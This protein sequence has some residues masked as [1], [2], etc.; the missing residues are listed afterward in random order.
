MAGSA[1]KVAIAMAG[2]PMAGGQASSLVQER[3]D[4]ENKKEA[5]ALENAEIYDEY[6]DLENKREALSLE[7]ARLAN[8]NMVLQNERLAQQNAA[9]RM[10]SQGVMMPSPMNHTHQWWAGMS[11]W[12]MPPAAC[13][14]LGYG[15]DLHM[16]TQSSMQSGR[17]QHKKTQ[18]GV[19]AKHAPSGGG[20][21]SC[22][23]ASFSS[24][25]TSYGPGSLTSISSLA[26]SEA[27]CFA[28]GPVPDHLR[29]TI[30]M[31]NI[32]NNYTREMLIELVS[33]EGFAGLYDLVYLPID[34][35]SKV[36]N[37]GYS[38]I[39]FV[40]PEV[41]TRFHS[42][43]NGFCQ[44]TLQSDKVCEVTWSDAIQGLDAHIERYKNS[45]V[46]HELVPDECK[47]AL[48]KGCERIPFPRPTMNIRAPR[49][50]QRKHQD[51]FAY[52]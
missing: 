35:Q 26:E 14:S 24:S 37:L 7:N 47:P 30:M 28:F 45:P 31:R 9:L 49:Q 16:T 13:N 18:N 40:D 34:F 42:H 21:G 4:L 20:E 8:E 5:L 36:A 46:M 22:P 48:F 51:D 52:Q 23:L 41:A 33:S 3:A 25:S 11:P 19:G 15:G 43:F 44:W 29:T 6:A 39:N 1:L 50:L 10:Q 2:P 32:P 12:G 38:F 27:S 17:Q